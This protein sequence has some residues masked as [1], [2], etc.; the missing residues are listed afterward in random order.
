MRQIKFRAFDYDRK[1]M[2]Y[3]DLETYDDRKHNNFGNLMFYTGFNDKNEKEIYEGDILEWKWNRMRKKRM[4]VGDI[5]GNY[6]MEI[7]SIAIIVGNIHENPDKLSRF[8]E[9]V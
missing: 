6:L 7:P 2:D 5:L 9:V 8:N 4:I 3:F 1:E